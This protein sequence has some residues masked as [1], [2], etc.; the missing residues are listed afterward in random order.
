[1][2]NVEVK[3]NR[4]H[5]DSLFTFMFG[6]FIE[7]LLEL[8]NAFAGTDITDTSLVEIVTLQGI[9]FLNRMNDIAFTIGDRLV[10]LI[11]HQSTVNNNLPLRL[12][13]YVARVYEKLIDNDAIYREKLIKLPHP[14][15]IV[16][17]NGE[18]DLPNGKDKMTTSVL[19]FSL[20]IN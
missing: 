14:Q 12:L 18:Q 8:Y 10:V 13:M 16:L 20:H 5:K 7:W 11:E 19:Y 15:F 6:N 4:E 3:P 1:M 2:E 17:Y 9:L